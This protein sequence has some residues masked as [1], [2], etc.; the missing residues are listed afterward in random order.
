M[1]IRTD[2]A[3]Y[4]VGETVYVKV[5][6]CNKGLKRIEYDVPTPCSPDI[7]VFAQ[8]KYGGQ[9]LWEEDYEPIGCFAVI[10]PRILDPGEK[11]EREV[12]WNQQVYQYNASLRAPSGK[13]EIHALFYAGRLTD[14]YEDLEVKV[15]V[16]IKI[17]EGAKDFL[18]SGEAV[19]ITLNDP[20]GSLWYESHRGENLLKFIGGQY[21]VNVEGELQRVT[22]EFAQELLKSEPEMS[23]ILKDTY[24]LVT[25]A[26]KL[27]DS[28]NELK[29]K[30]DIYSGEILSIFEG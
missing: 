19:Q 4:K 11:I 13:Y 15:S 27:G 20:E 30:I 17:K 26:Q 25:F 10:D 23:V 12:V 18:T 2:K 14:Y 28:P 29:I 8:T 7:V 6:L 3:E 5:I 21:Y 16:S 9:M 1:E 24:W 22:D